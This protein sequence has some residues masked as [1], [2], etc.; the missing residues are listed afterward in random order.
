MSFGG[1]LKV[2]LANKSQ[3]SAI[4]KNASNVITGITMSGG[5]KFY[6]FDFEV[7]AGAGLQET[8]QVGT[9]TFVQ[10]ILSFNIKNISQDLKAI[11]SKMAVGRMV[12]IVQYP[13]G[14]YR[15]A[16][17]TGLGLRATQ[18]E[19]NSGR[20][21]T[22]FVGALIALTGDVLDYSNEVTSAAIAAVD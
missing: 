4:N 20:V 6:S 3:V 2:Y 11:L 16:G 14:D 9:N 13:N 21:N 7:Q 12:A 10:Q 5:A 18:L 17:E 19:F 8:L 1:L 15:M 22:D